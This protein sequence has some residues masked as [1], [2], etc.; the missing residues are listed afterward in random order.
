MGYVHGHQESRGGHQDE[1]QG[2]ES[3]VRDGEELVV[4]DGV[5]TGLLGVTGE[6]GLLVAPD[7]LGRHNEDHDTKDE[8]DGEP[9]AANASGM[10][11]YTA[12]HGVKGPPVHFRFQVWRAETTKENVA[13]NSAS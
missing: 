10:P 7:R 9:D 3:N 6:A 12:D 1:L 5:A 13:D 4:A 2:P 8:D 11:V